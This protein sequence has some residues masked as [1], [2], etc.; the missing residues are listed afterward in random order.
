[1]D[2][3]Q[4]DSMDMLSWHFPNSMEVKPFT[5]EIHTP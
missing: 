4:I 5:F 2:K 1:M 3:N